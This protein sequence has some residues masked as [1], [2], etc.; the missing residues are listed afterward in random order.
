MKLFKII[1]AL[2]LAVSVVTLLVCVNIRSI[3]KKSYN[4]IRDS[5]LDDIFRNT[6]KTNVQVSPESAHR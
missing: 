3:S 4:E 1:A 2:A 6:R 5:R